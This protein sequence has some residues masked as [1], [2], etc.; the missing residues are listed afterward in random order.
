MIHIDQIIKDMEIMDDD[1]DRYQY[2]IELGKKLPI[3]PKEKQI[4]SNMEKEC[5]SALWR[6]IE[7]ENIEGD[8]HIIKLYLFSD[9]HIIRGLLYIVQ[10]IYEGKKAHEIAKINSTKI[11]NEMQLIEILSIKRTNGIYSVIGKINTAAKQCMINNHL[12]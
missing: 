7:F 10:S 9:S 6:S 2:L 4:E 1:N 5:A 8:Y 12:K 3:F 11:F